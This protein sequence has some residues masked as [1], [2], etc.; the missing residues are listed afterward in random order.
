VIK[1]KGTIEVFDI[2]G[3]V[4][5]PRTVIQNKIVDTGYDSFAKAV[6]GVSSFVVN[7]MYAKFTNGTPSEPTIPDDRVAADYLSLGTDEGFVR[8]KTLT[9]PEFSTSAAGTYLSNIATFVGVAGDTAETTGEP[10]VDGVSQFVELGLVAIPDFTA[11][12]QDTL[13]SAGVILDRHGD[14]SPLAKIANS[15]CGFRWSIK[16]ERA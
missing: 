5:L 16:F 8:F 7:G 15:Q 3:G 12:A 13:V 4:W 2:L 14:F 9:T 1:I 6:A 11:I 10:L